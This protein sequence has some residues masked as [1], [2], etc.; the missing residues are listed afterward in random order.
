MTKVK[1]KKGD[2]VIV[3]SGKYKG[4]TG[5]LIDVHPKINKVTIE[6]INIAKKHIKPTRVSPKGGIIEVNRPLGVSKVGLYDSAN[7]KASRVGIKIG[8][9]GLKKRLMKSS[10]KEIN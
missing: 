1:L 2:V 6:G 10:G 9:D 5:K 4:R 7:K 8:K 3:R